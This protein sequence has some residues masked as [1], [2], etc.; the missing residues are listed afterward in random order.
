[1]RRISLIFTGAVLCAALAFACTAAAKPLNKPVTMTCTTHS[2]RVVSPVIKGHL[3]A[4]NVNKWQMKYATCDVAKR[5]M[6]RI[7]NKGIEEPTSVEGFRCEPTVEATNPDKVH[8]RCA[9]KSAD[10]P[11]FVRL[12]FRVK[13][14]NS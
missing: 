9:F 11:M 4:R 8:Y 10:T 1:M 2:E 3:L 5:V 12:A 14:A 7:I 13:Y 6:N